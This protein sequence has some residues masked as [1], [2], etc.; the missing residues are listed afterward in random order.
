MEP[1][2]WLS[3]RRLQKRPERR[4]RD[5]DPSALTWLVAL[6]GM[7]LPWIGAGLGI[8]GA[9]QVARYNGYGWCLIGAGAAALIA[10]LLIDVL[11]AKFAIGTTDQ[12]DLNRRAAQLIGR[13]LVVAEAI[14][15]GRGKVRA[16][17]TLW[18]VEGPDTPAG[19]SVSVTGT[20]G[21]ALVVERVEG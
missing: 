1:C 5:G 4:P 12:P 19:G 13:L 3:V 6:V 16:G 17:D 18:P 21:T 7:A 2:W 9:W 10:D 20:N 8:A 15:G 11:F 14:E